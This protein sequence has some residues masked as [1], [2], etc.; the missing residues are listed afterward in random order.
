MQFSDS[1]VTLQITEE[2]LN[3]KKTQVKKNRN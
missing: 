3:N 2:L 1:A